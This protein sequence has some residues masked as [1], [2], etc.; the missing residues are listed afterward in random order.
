M[1]ELVMFNPWELLLYF[2]T[3]NCALVAAST[4]VDPFIDV[5]F[6]S[7][8]VLIV[9]SYFVYVRPGYVEVTLRDQTKYRIEGLLLQSLHAAFHVLPYALVVLWLKP[10]YRVEYGK[11]FVSMVL[12]Y[13]FGVVVNV[14]KLYKISRQEIMLL[15]MLPVIILQW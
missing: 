12:M 9:S 6:T 5:V 14:E 7:L 13:V 2:T 4:L 1:H 15:A 11:L 8:A 10:C 3:W